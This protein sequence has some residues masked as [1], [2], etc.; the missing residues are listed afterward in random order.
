[1][2]QQAHGGLAG[3]FL[4][5][6]LVLPSCASTG[7]RSDASRD[8]TAD[9]ADGGAMTADS[10]WTGPTVMDGSIALG[11]GATAVCP[12][13]TAQITQYILNPQ[14]GTCHGSTGTMGSLDLL[15][16]G[17]EA[18]L[19]NQPS[20]L[21]DN[22]T[23]VIPGNPDRSYFFR[24]MV[25]AMPHCGDR[26]PQ[27]HPPLDDVLLACLRNWL[28]AGLPATPPDAPMPTVDG[29]TPWMPTPGTTTACR[30]RH[31]PTM[32]PGNACQDCHRVG[33][34]APN[35]DV[36]WT[37]SGTVY[38]GNTAAQRSGVAG[39]VVVITDA[40][41]AELRLDPSNSAGNFFDQTPVQFP[42]RAAI[43]YNG[44]R[45]EMPI[46]L[47]DGNCNHCHTLPSVQGTSGRLYVAP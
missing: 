16:P 3:L 22:E 6:L 15:S 44:T 38:A 4:G 33:G 12:V 46:P 37:I 8:G 2:K 19:L 24:K 29:G 45:I 47:T 27:G 35:F 26:M 5:A 34:E 11:D 40:T 13:G 14:C 17:V 18:R 10:A 31:I 42:A 28:N 25:D 30:D 7:N 1:M 39:A 43:E 23:L 32:C 41:G 36:R 9:G 20:V 21:C